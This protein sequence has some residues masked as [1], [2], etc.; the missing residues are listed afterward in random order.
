M[1]WE[2]DEAM[3]GRERKGL[4]SN[5]HMEM[6]VTKVRS[7]LCSRVQRAGVLNPLQ[8]LQY[9]KLRDAVRKAKVCGGVPQVLDMPKQAVCKVQDKV[10]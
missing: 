10:Q 6:S 1:V 9:G 8:R 4:Q 3:Q 7:G 2:A 5:L